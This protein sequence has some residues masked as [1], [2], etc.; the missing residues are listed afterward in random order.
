[1]RILFI[2]IAALF[3]SFPAAVAQESIPMCESQQELEQV[4][5]SSGQIMP[6]GCRNV[7]VSELEQDGQRLCLLDFS[8]GDEGFVDQLRDVAV[9]QQW[10]AAC[11]DIAASTQ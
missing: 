1:M 5:G 11:E 2:S 3:M 9:S 7:A 6:D 10:W 4:L 8:T